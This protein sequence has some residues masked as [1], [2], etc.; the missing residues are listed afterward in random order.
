MVDVAMRE[1]PK[2]KISLKVW[3]K[4][5]QYVLYK[6]SAGVNIGPMGKTLKKY[7]N[8][9]MV[10]LHLIESDDITHPVRRVGKWVQ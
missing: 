10:F 5:C 4:M 2:M 1:H 8:V 9:K 3:L 6:I 7:I